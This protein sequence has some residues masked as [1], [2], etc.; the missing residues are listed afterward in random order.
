MPDVITDT[1]RR[2]WC[3]QN[4][5]VI[6]PDELD[7]VLVVPTDKRAEEYYGKFRMSLTPTVA[8]AVGQ[9]MIALADELE[10]K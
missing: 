8:R 5:I 2:V 1:V 10:K 9:A 7:M 3:E 6:S 4:A